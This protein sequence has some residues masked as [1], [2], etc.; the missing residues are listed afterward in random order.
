MKL[1]LA[2]LLVGF[3][4]STLY[5]LDMEQGN[6]DNSQS[7]LRI[8]FDD[9]EN[10]D[11]ANDEE[12]LELALQRSLETATAAESFRKKQAEYVNAKRRP[13]GNVMFEALKRDAGNTA[14]NSTDV[15]ELQLMVNRVRDVLRFANLTDV[16]QG[17]AEG[18]LISLAIQ[19]SKL[20]S[21]ERLGALKDSVSR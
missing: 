1:N 13:M 9:E 4:T 7:E 12:R 14:G 19:M 3:I 16:Q 18:L 10:L 21:A 5:A 17:E 15:N 11:N 8:V 6:E 2:F 20:S